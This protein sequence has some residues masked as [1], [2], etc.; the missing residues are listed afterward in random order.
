MNELLNHIGE[1]ILFY[2]QQGVQFRNFQPGMGPFG[3]PQLV[4]KIK[5]YF[6]ANL[7]LIYP[8]TTTRRH[9]DM[10]I[11]DQW[12]LEY[13][14]LSP[15]GDNGRIME[16]WSEN[17]IHPYPGNVS[18]LSDCYNLNGYPAGIRK[19]IIVVS[20]EPIQPIIDLNILL[21]SFELIAENICHFN[22][23][24]RF[25]HVV[26]GLIHPVFQKVTIYGWEL[27]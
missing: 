2:D 3:E 26:N 22:L 11:P 5:D 14:T 25:S 7:P 21:D 13:K 9:P 6:L 20:F 27:L 4:S 1:A 8:G 19:G 16:H 18:A 15:Y 17:L 24:P 12:A 23:G 10:I